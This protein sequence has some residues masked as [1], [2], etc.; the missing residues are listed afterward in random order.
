MMRMA[1]GTGGA[2][3]F[4]YFLLGKQEKVTGRRAAPGIAY[5]NER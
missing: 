1:R 2:V 5:L 3:L 4:G